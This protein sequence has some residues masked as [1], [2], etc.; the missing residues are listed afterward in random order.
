LKKVAMNTFAQRWGIALLAAMICAATSCGRAGEGEEAAPSSGALSESVMSA[1]QRDAVK[2]RVVTPDEYHAAYRRFA[3]CMSQAGYTL[4][5]EGEERGVLKY[6]VPG[7]AVA[8]GVDEKCYN[9]EFSA[10]DESWQ[11]AHEEESEGAEVLRACLKK[12]GLEPGANNAERQQILEKAGH[13]L[14]ECG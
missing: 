10:V 9:Q 8:S 12:F 14:Q 6:S 1:E 13:T 11:L 2:D 5:E 7:T 4:I 3:S